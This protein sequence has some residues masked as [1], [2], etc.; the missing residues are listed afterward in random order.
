MEVIARLQGIPT[1]DK[2]GNCIVS[3]N[4]GKNKKQAHKIFDDFNGRDILVKMKLYKKLRSNEQNRYFWKCVSILAS[5]LGNDNWD[6]YLNELEKYG[7]FSSIIIEKEAYND[8]RNMW[9]ETKIVGERRDSNGNE[10]FDVNCYY[11]SS[12]Y[13]TGEMSRLIDGVRQDLADAG[14]DIPVM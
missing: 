5:G 13:D 3:I 10:Y 12:T 1:E 6:Q 4:M 8:F 7:K 9:R 11:G 2:D 14:L